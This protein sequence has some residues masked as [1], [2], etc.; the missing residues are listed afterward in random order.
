MFNCKVMQ[1]NETYS[2]YLPLSTISIVPTIEQVVWSPGGGRLS[3][4][5]RRHQELGM[6]GRQEK[7]KHGPSL[8]VHRVDL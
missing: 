1:D 7:G 2:T 8:A 6:S 4:W 3:Q 5:A